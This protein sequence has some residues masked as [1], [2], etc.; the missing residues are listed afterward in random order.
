MLIIFGFFSFI[1][2]L[3]YYVCY[4]AGETPIDQNNYR[5]NIDFRVN[6]SVDFVIRSGSLSV[7]WMES[8][9]VFCL[10]LRLIGL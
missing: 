10:W 8:V 6:E 4:L 1:P 3:L 7:L 2:Y 5:R 9:D